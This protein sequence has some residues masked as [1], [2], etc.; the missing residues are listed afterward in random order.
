MKDLDTAGVAV[1]A[2]DLASLP[3]LKRLGVTAAA[4]A[5]CYLYT[6]FGDIDCLADILHQM[7][8]T[9]L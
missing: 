2:G 9:K 7:Q 4:R 3:L 1:R 6:D 5:S 8:R